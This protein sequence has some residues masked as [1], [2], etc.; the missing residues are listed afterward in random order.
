MRER[1]RQS[2]LI[3]ISKALLILLLLPGKVAPLSIHYSLL[4]F[5]DPFKSFSHTFL[6]SSLFSSTNLAPSLQLFPHLS[7][8]PSIGHL[9]IYLSLV[10]YGSNEG[11]GS[12]L[13]IWHRFIYGLVYRLS[14]YLLFNLFIF[15]YRHV[16]RL[17]I[18]DFSP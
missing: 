17:H 9:P 18:V 7:V 12:S 3:F 15:L 2:T 8:Y 11:Y 5:Q 13:E 4:F 1:Q 10:R 14:N 6:L 16:Y